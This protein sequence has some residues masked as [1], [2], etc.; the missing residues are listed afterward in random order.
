VS[1]DDGY[2]SQSSYIERGSLGVILVSKNK[3]D[4]FSDRS[5]L[6]ESSIDVV[7]RDRFRES[8]DRDVLCS[9]KVFIDKEASGTRVE[10]S[11]DCDRVVARNGFDLDLKFGAVPI[12]YGAD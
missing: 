1:Q 10:K 9:Y 6:I 2:S 7:D 5:V 11:L 12:G 4:S 3:V 8:S